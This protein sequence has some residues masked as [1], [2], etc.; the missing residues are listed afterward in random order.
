MSQVPL[1]TVQR[2]IGVGSRDFILLVC[3]QWISQLGDGIYNVALPLFALAEWGTGA[4]LGLIMATALFPFTLLAPFAGVF[5]DRWNRR[6]VIIFADLARGVITLGVAYLAWTDLLTIPLLVLATG[7][8][9]AASAF[10]QPAIMA[11]MP[12][13]VGRSELPRAAS[14][15]EMGRS[16]AR[17]L[18]PALGGVLIVALGFP[19][20]FLINGV[21]FMVSALSAAFIYIPQTAKAKTLTVIQDLR[22]GIR[23]VL[24]S[25]LLMGLM[26]VLCVMNFFEPAVLPVLMPI[27]A[28]KVL[29]VGSAGY[30]WM[31]AVA[32]LGG[33][34]ALIILA[35]AKKTAKRHPI[36]IGSLVGTG[37][38]FILLGFYPGYYAT[39]GLLFVYGLL[40]GL[41]NTLLIVLFIGYVPDEVRGKIIGIVSTVSAGMIPIAF[42][43]IGALADL[44][45]IGPIL[46]VSGA[47]VA[48]AALALYRVRGM[49]DI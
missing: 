10:F 1:A 33:F 48:I 28:K 31:R 30:G 41:A 3:G 26:L 22:E 6:L 32:G 49:A 17:V 25:Q 43:T 47:A 16:I 19:L 40:V 12:N 11:S 5:A 38:S 29:L 35:L 23:F 15:L 2:K 46:M 4:S 42:L 14:L 8:V 37:A 24:K 27:A 36:L 7:L 34:V 39:L 20:V 44:I 18:G 21:S 13:M 9:S 45:S